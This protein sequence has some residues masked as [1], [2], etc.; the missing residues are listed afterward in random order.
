MI[1]I[2]GSPVC[3]PSGVVRTDRVP[4]VT[5]DRAQHV[6]REFARLTGAPPAGVWA[7]PGRANLIGEHTD[8]NDGFVMP[9]ALDQRITIAGA[10]RSDDTWSVTSLDNGETQTFTRADLRPGMS[11]WQ[12]YVAGVVWALIE[13]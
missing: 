13:A 7:A 2:L 6:T 9:F 12:A 4:D 8:Y 1:A 11:G 3:L 5:D 10:P